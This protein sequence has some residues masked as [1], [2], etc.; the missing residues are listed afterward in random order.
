MNICVIIYLYEKKSEVKN[1][2]GSAKSK[3]AKKN[4]GFSF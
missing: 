4:I 3:Y 1:N 2:V